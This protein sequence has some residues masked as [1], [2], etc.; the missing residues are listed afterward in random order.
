M[1]GEQIGTER[2]KVTGYRI[3]PSEGAGPKVEMAFQAA[4][5]I[6][7]VE[8]STLATYTS[9]MRPDGTVLGEGQGV[10]RGTKGQM[11]SWVGQGVGKLGRGQAISYRG[12]IYYQSASPD[13]SRLNHVATMFEYE[14]D[15]QGNTDAK[16]WEWK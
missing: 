7:G 3:L 11:A 4:G 15:E 5:T 13:W 8:H 12:A 16:F 10:V 1:L 9:I 14:V 2:G 6:L